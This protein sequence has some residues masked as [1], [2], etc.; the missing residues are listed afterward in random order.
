MF[1]LQYHEKYTV[2]SETLLMLSSMSSGTDFEAQIKREIIVVIHFS[3]LFA[4][5]FYQ[6]TI[7]VCELV[8]HSRD[9]SQRVIYIDKIYG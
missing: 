1:S 3:S 4:R 7:G 8:Q 9:C 2:L 6:I 5:A